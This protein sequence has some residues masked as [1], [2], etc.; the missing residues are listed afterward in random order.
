[1]EIRI[2]ITDTGSPELACTSVAQPQVKSSHETATAAPPKQIGAKAAR[3]GALSAGAAP[4]FM[5]SSTQP[6]APAPFMTGPSST[7]SIAAGIGHGA[8]ESAGPARGS[9]QLI[10]PFNT[11]GSNSGGGQ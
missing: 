10:K 11:A 2:T 7:I 9:G 4:S 3:L 6:G 5:A 8:A 1:M